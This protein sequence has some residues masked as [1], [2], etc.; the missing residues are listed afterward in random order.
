MADDLTKKMCVSCEGKGLK[1]F[2]KSQ[3]EDYLTQTKGWIKTL[4]EDCIPKNE[5]SK[6]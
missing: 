2:S 4:C 6:D 3:A 1:P 5:K